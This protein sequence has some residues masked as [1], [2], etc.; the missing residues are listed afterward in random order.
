MNG[1]N[2]AASVDSPITLVSHFVA[3]RRLAT[4]QRRSA[5]SIDCEG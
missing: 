2:F 1:S 4:E 5:S 3:Q